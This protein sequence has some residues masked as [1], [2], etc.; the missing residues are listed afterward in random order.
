MSTPEDKKP[1]LVDAAKTKLKASRFRFLNEL[2]YTQTGRKSLEMFTQDP[3]AFQTYH[4]GYSDQVKK[5]PLNPL[6]LIVKAIMKRSDSPVVADFGCGEAK[7]AEMLQ[8]SCQKIHSFDLVAANDRVTVCDFSRTPL[9]DGSV[10]IA[11]FCLSLMGSNLRDYLHE[12]NRVLKDNGTMKIAEVE[13]R[14]TGEVSVDKFVS[15]VEKLGFKLKW[16]DLKHDYFYLMDFKKVGPAKMKKVSEF[17][18]K[19]CLYKK[20]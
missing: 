14:F 4:Q 15:I 1:G 8:K 2:L 7:L 6:D 17:N 11:V 9:K 13:S 16:K 5:W 12:A 18:L 3:D 10:D 19:P 20:R